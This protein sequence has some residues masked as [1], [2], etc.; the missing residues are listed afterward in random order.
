MLYQNVV[1][2]NL[3]LREENE[4]LK[5]DYEGMKAYCNDLT[6]IN[7]D[8]IR[9]DENDKSTIKELVEVLEKARS[10]AYCLHGDLVREIDSVLSKVNNTKQEG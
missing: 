6:K 5:A 1:N 3:E 10:S 8:N 2:S 4:R 9:I 7:I